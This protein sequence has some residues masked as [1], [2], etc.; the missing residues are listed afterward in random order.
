VPHA[1][2]LLIKRFERSEA[3]E[4]FERL[5]LL[6]PDYYLLPRAFSLKKAT[7]NKKL[8]PWR[9]TSRMWVRSSTSGIRRDEV[10]LP[11]LW[12]SRDFNGSSDYLNS[13]A[14]IDLSGV[15][16]ICVRP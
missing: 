9:P 5:E 1:S 12:A 8:D 6:I 16:K 10:S 11:P 14:T 2:C 7:V 3:V 4:R 13:T 15:N